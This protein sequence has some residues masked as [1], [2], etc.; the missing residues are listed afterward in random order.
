MRLTT[1]LYTIPEILSVGIKNFEIKSYQRGYRWDIENI[2]Q[3]INDVIESDP[4]KIYCMQP[5]VVTELDETTFEVIDGQ[6]RLTTFKI[7]VHC[8]KSLTGKSTIDDYKITYETRS[9]KTFLEKIY[10]NQL[11]SQLTEL[12]VEQ[13]SVLWNNL[14]L[15]RGEVNRDNFHLYQSYCACIFLLK[16]LSEN[17]LVD[18]TNKLK[19]NVKFIWYEVDLKTLNTTA[20][21]LFSNINRNKIRLTGADLIKALLILDIE[22]RNDINVEVKHYEKQTLSNEWNEVEQMLG[23]SDFWFFITN[24]REQNYD[25]RIGK[26]FD[27]LTENKQETDLGSYFILKKNPEKRNWSS[28]YKSFKMALEWYEDYNLYHRIGF[29][30]NMDIKNFNEILLKYNE[31]TTLSKKVFE[32]WINTQIE[33]YINEIK[34]SELDYNKHKGRFGYCTGYLILYNILLLE[35][36]YP[37]HKFSFG[38]LVEQEWSLE[39]IQPQKPRDKNPYAWLVWLKEIEISIS[40][41]FICENK[42]IIKVDQNQYNI[43]EIDFENLIESL[44]VQVSVSKDLLVQLEILQNLF[45]EEF[46]SHKIQN[47]ALLDKITNSKLSN[48]SFKEKRRL[49]LQFNE[50]EGREKVYLPLGTI[51][52]FSKSMVSSTNDLQLE[53]WSTTDSEYYFSEINS[54]LKPYMDE[55]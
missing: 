7:L 40:D 29:L 32:N 55:K 14:K 11:K 33:V 41:K 22:R 38:D 28:V 53:Y 9:C 10:R 35:K 36:F 46:P 15:E 52:V 47:L 6:Q 45:E 1:D 48:N 43:S 5:L 20:E 13:V 27:I 44:K 25:V 12:K 30:V 34:I 23:D 16:D 2:E 37:H 42:K 17:D 3:F 31:P 39:H 18:L 26:L 50:Q 49:I 21:K 8:L 19:N 51:N 54:I 24:T 4:N